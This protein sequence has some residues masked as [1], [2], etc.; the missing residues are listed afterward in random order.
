MAKLKDRYANAL[1][2]LSEESGSLEKDFE[3][4][5]LVRDTLKSADV[6][7][8]LA[9]PHVPVSAKHQ[10][11]HNAFSGKLAKHLKGFLYLVVRKNREALIVPALTEYIDRINRRLGRIEAKVVSAKA[12]TDKQIESIRTVLSKKIDM[13]V[14]VKAT[15]DP[16]VI[17]GF[18][19]LVD[20]RIFDGTVRT[21]L[22]IMMESLRKGSYE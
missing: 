18:Y 6:Q 19:V 15:V 16:D 9:H 17:G 12:L 5:V 21:Q 22:N 4:A 11:L 8:F 2:E 10:L 1:L 14:E 20:G 13:Q 3:Q 7:A